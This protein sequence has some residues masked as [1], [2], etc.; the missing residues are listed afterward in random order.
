MSVVCNSD[1]KA[2]AKIRKIFCSEVEMNA[3]DIQNSLV[4]EL[5][6]FVFHFGHHSSKMSSYYNPI[7]LVQYTVYN[8]Q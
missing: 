5:E 4:E 2:M 3:Y 8:I 1:D 7:L 6:H